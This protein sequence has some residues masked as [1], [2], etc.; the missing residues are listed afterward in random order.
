M[1]N[2]NK[3][4]SLINRKKTI[5]VNLSENFR[6]EQI[7]K[8]NDILCVA[9]NNSEFYKEIYQE[10][11]VTL[12]IKIG[13]FSDLK[14]LPVIKKEAFRSALNSDT[15]RTRMFKDEDVFSSSTTGSTGQPMT[16]HFD[17]ECIK[18]RKEILSLLSTITGMGYDKK[19]CRIWRQKSL[20]KKEEWYQRLGGLLQISVGD[21]NSPESTSI[22]KSRLNEIINSISSYKPETI[23]GYVSA[24]Y[25]IMTEMQRQGIEID[26]LESVITSAEYL[27]E[28]IWREFEQ[29]FNCKV[30][31]LYGGTEAPAIALNFE[32]SRNLSIFEE[33]Y[34]VEVLDDEG[35]DC[36]PGEPGFITIT[37]L[38]SK[39]VPLIR[40]QIGDIAT[41]DSHFFELNS[42]RRYFNAVEG[43]TNDIFCLSDGSLIFSHLWHIHF[44]GYEWLNMFK[45]EQLELDEILI[46][47]ACNENDFSSNIKKIKNDIEN[48]YPSV[49]FTWKQ[50]EHIPSG[51]G[52]KVRN[53]VS[54]VGNKFNMVNK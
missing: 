20:S 26:S 49:T 9:C 8:I 43:R 32:H 10:L 45:V 22:D 16:M 25:T 3:I 5:D 6:S 38:Y 46:S 44:R 41:V 40:Y 21:V 50:V 28:K 1:L 14:A 47:L 13:D 23:R 53:I 15:L 17:S 30:F 19:V 39:E 7:D 24:L 27:P 52:N 42:T 37:D 29:Y 54:Y 11:G 33:L 51:K 18:K 4:Y 36:K 34:F 12:P 31:N 2:L 48:K 35:N